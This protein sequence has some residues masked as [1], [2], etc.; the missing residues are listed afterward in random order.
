MRTRTLGSIL[1]TGILL[2]GVTGCTGPDDPD[3]PS[4]GTGKPTIVTDM[5]PTTFAVQQVVGDSAEVIQLTPA[6]VEPHDYE[7]SPAQVAQI[8]DAD[9]VAY[10]PG[11][12]PAVEQAARQEAGDHALDVTAGIT[13]IASDPDH[14][15]DLDPHVWL[16]PKN[17]AAMGANVAAALTKLGVTADAAPLAT[18]MDSLDQDISAQLAQC[19]ITT[20]VVSHAAFG[21]L[22]AAY[23]FTQVGISGL[24]PEAE[25]SPA[26]LAEISDLVSEKGITTIYAEV[27]LSPEAAA[28]IAD[29]TGAT[30]AVL[31]PIEGN[32][33]DHGYV[34]LMLANADTLHAGQGCS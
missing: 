11:L 1:V 23:G 22:A 21:Y 26:R 32:T 31:D 5:Y 28:T 7:L 20:M 2:V 15:Q 3:A 27:L 24:S 10:L 18:Q 34:S 17:V 16:D 25:P 6:G 30:V 14:P 19:S 29:E 8:A 13:K 4:T 33:E 9:L 12:I